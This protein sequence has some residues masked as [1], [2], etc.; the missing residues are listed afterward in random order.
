MRLFDAAHVT[1]ICLWSVRRKGHVRVFRSD[2]GDV[3]IILCC[4]EAPSIS[5]RLRSR[6]ITMLVGH[7]WPYTAFDTFSRPEA[8][9]S[10][11]AQITLI[12]NQDGPK[13]SSRSSDPESIASLVAGIC[14]EFAVACAISFAEYHHR[15]LDV[16]RL[17][18]EEI[19]IALLMRDQ[20]RLTAIFRKALHIAECGHCR[21][22]SA[23]SDS[24]GRRTEDNADL[25]LRT[26]EQK[27]SGA[28][29]I[30]CARP[31][32]VVYQ[33]SATVFKAMKLE[34]WSPKELLIRINERLD[35][36]GASPSA[37]T[38]PERPEGDITNAAPASYTGLEM[39]ER[40]LSTDAYA[41]LLSIA[42]IGGWTATVIVKLIGEHLDPTLP[43]YL[44]PH[45]NSVSGPDWQRLHT[46]VFQGNEGVL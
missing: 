41:N 43:P 30:P 45:N 20:E 39:E 11:L 27:A 21:T 28:S 32:A 8:L 46:W 42:E 2:A 13:V 24:H 9:A 1:E 36:S 26:L 25:L 5:L 6:D 3:V 44:V 15:I 34:G 18:Q 29:P 14:I 38:V 33:L 40:Q 23:T 17:S 37:Q 7:L 31:R 19:T 12:A 4:T 16:T 10:A 35:P 22:N